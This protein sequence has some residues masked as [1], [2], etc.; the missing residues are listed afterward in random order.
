[1]KSHYH[2]NSSHILLVYGDT[3]KYP[4]CMVHNYTVLICSRPQKCLNLSFYENN[5]DDLD[6]QA[7]KSNNTIQIFSHNLNYK[8][9]AHNRIEMEEQFAWKNDT[10]N[11]NIESRY[12]HFHCMAQYKI[13]LLF[14]NVIYH[15]SSFQLL[16][17]SHLP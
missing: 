8:L 15:G 2:I 16:G 7:T 4:L 9:L 12:I 5:F 1:M 10:F 3:H 17:F 14:T 13:Q 11:L 6:L